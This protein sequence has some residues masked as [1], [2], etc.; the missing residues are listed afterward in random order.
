MNEPKP[1]VVSACLFGEACRYDGGSKPNE[2]VIALRKRYR[3]VPVCPESLGGLPIPREPSEICGDRVLSRT[4][5]DVTSAYLL[6]ARKTLEQATRH[7]CRAALL[8]E[9]SP[10]CGK[11]L[12]HNGRFDGG[13]IAGNGVTTALLMQNGVAVFGESEMDALERFLETDK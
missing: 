5:S 12:I 13:L 11:G 2:A 7:G 9:K 6:G 1:I 3:L 8:K 10:S 4:G